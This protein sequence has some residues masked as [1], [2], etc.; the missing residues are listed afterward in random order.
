[1]PEDLS[2]VV[3]S[4]VAVSVGAIGVS[5]T[6]ISI[7]SISSV[8]VGLGLSLGLP[9][10]VVVSVVS[11]AKTRVPVATIAGVAKT[12]SSIVVGL[13][14]SLSL[15]LAVVKTVVGAVQSMAV[16]DSSHNSDIVGVAS[17]VSVVDGESVGD[18]A[19]CVGLG[20]GLGLS[21]RVPLAV[22]GAGVGIAVDS[23]VADGS[24]S[25]DMAVTIVHTGDDAA[26]GGAVGNL[27]DGVGLAADAG[28]EGADLR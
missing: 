3:S 14:L 26:I 22:V 20:L 27:A 25:R 12:V 9:L 15:S 28:D 21:L 23:P 1:M 5:G 10:A 11:I 24:I 7:S 19:D 13:G 16:T 4:A 6:G 2:P 18:L 8:V 17:G